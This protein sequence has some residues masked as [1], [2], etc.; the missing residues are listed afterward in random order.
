MQT[1]LAETLL[2][3][4]RDFAD[5]T[6]LVDVEGMSTP[7]VC[8]LL[9]GLVAGMDPGERYL[10]IGCWKGL[11][12]VS[13]AFGNEGRECI[14]CDKFRFWGRYTGWGSDVRA[15]FR[16]N[17]ARHQRG[18]AKITFHEMSSRRL[19]AE[20]RVQ[21]PIGVYFYDGDHSYEE[22]RRS[23][24]RAA[25]LLSARATIVVDD[26]NDPEIRR[27]TFDAIHDARLSLLWHRQLEGTHDGR[28]FWNGIGVFYVAR[29][30]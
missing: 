3:D 6:P 24:A 10:E 17:V 8:R 26:W 7:Q 21:G 14:A 18:S 15:A 22:T 12:L 28:G 13:A 27:A 30:S 4:S 25:P 16:R 11:T 20:R 1:N 29:P 5:A 2:R 23:I 19:F 9:N